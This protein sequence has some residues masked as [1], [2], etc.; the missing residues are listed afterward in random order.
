V[1]SYHTVC[2]DAYTHSFNVVM[3]QQYQ[4]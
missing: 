1:S 4:Y 2:T 3:V